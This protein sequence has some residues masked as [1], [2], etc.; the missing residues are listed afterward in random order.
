MKLLVIGASS[1][2]GAHFCDYA[3]SKGAEVHE[4]SLR[5][6]KALSAELAEPQEYIVNFAALNVV[7]PSWEYPSDYLFTNTYALTGVIDMLKDKPLIKFVQVSTPEVY[8]STSGWVK[9]GHPFN[10]S[11]PYAVSRAAAD[12]MLN[13][14]AKEYL[15]PIAITRACNVYGP[16]QQLYRMIPK[17]IACIRSGRKFPLEGAGQSSRC[18]LHVRDACDAIWRVMMLG[19][20]EYHISTR[21]LQSIHAIVKHIC[22]RIGIPM[23][24]AVEVTP[25]RPGKDSA[26]M[27]DSGKIRAELGWQDT[28]SMD[29]GL[30]E[31]IEWIDKKY[32]TWEGVS[33]DYQHRP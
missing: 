5:S 21:E 11:T 7:A 27:L 13:C 12:M 14:Y 6:L 10:P 17:V 32:K 28:V 24:K 4:A 31:V 19:M 33:L 8:G 25:E 30:D 20:G 16:R 18:F 1:F 29:E 22:E 15:M 26:Y 23:D 2:T 3:R 9:E